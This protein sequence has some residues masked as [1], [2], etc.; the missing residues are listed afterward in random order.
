M[1]PLETRQLP[2]LARATFRGRG[3]QPFPVCVSRSASLARSIPLRINKWVTPSPFVGSAGSTTWSPVRGLLRCEVSLALGRDLFVS[4]ETKPEYYEYSQ[5]DIMKSDLSTEMVT[6]KKSKKK[7]SEGGEVTKTK[8][9]K[10]NKKSDSEKENIS[11]VEIEA[12]NPHLRGGRVENHLGKT[13]P[14]SPDRDSNLD[15]LILSS[16]A[17]HDKR[18]SQ[19]RHRGGYETPST[20]SGETFTHPP[21]LPEKH[22]LTLRFFRRNIY[23]PSAS[24]GETFTHPPLLPEKHLLTLH[25]FHA[26]PLTNGCAPLT[27]NTRDLDQHSTQKVEETEPP[28][29]PGTDPAPPDDDFSNV[30]VK[31]LKSAFSNHVQTQPSKESIKEFDEDIL[32]CGPIKSLKQTF[33]S[34][35]N[36]TFDKRENFDG[37]ERIAT[38][39]SIKDLR[40]SFGD[41]TNLVDSDEVD[42]VVF[43][44]QSDQAGL[45]LELWWLGPRREDGGGNIA[46]MLPSLGPQGFGPKIQSNKFK[47]QLYKM[48]Y[49]KI[50]MESNEMLIHTKN[51]GARQASDCRS[52]SPPIHVSRSTG[53]L[54]LGWKACS[55]GDLRGVS[56]SFQP[57]SIPSAR[58]SDMEEAIVETGIS[59]RALRANYC[60]Q[61]H[62][63]EEL[64]APPWKIQ[65]VESSVIARGAPIR[66]VNSEVSEAA[67]LG[68]G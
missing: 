20:S 25:L 47:K 42:Q 4:L 62:L 2:N 60:N 39:V 5:V 64:E 23:S 37:K 29:S 61:A 51:I 24:S 19:L 45:E 59:V 68:M 33:C 55:L 12:V 41:L 35:A 50:R 16:R 26:V 1:R 28:T 65:P 48:K 46:T 9:T 43:E 63:K 14:S 7:R 27:H 6:E 36:K 67:C 58:N 10:K 57:P 31:V 49:N 32:Y 44:T 38:G 52:R 21:L 13:T 34:E 40:R 54:N 66:V 22:L 8:K 15:L 53:K 3:R 11:V 30:S 17:Q 56:D 18:V